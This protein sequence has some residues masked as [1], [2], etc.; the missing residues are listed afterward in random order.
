MDTSAALSPYWLTFLAAQVF[1]SAPGFLSAQIKVTSLIQDKGDTHH[2]F[3][4]AYLQKLGIQKGQYN[5]IANYVKCPSDVNRLIS[6]K[7]PAVYFAEVREQLGKSGQLSHLP[8]EKALEENLN[9]N[10]IPLEV[11]GAQISYEDFLFERRRLMAR[12]ISDY[13]EKL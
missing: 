4:K 8:D 3:P 2:V 13:V 7:P 12:R 6:D 10:A 5:Q 9:K 11:L 1:D